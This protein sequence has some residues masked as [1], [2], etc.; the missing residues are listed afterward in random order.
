MVTLE[1]VG[2]CTSTYSGDT[3]I[4]EPAPEDHAIEDTENCDEE[5]GNLASSSISLDGKH[6]L[7][8]M[9]VKLPMGVTIMI[10][11]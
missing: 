11:L 6:L 7:F 5:P 3:A 4:E 2:I 10:T 9:I 8:S 1:D